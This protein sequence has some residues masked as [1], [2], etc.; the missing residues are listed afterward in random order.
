MNY[1]ELLDRFWGMDRTFSDKEVILYHY[2]LYRCNSFGW[3]DTFSLSNE[4][5]IGALMCRPTAM[6][7]A[8]SGLVEAGLISFQARFGRGENSVYSITDAPQKKVRNGNTFLTKKGTEWEHLFDEKKVR[9]G[10]TFSDSS[11]SISAN[12]ENDD[13]KKGTE[14]EHLFNEKKEEKQEKKIFP[15][16]PPIKEKKEKKKSAHTI[17]AHTP[18]CAN[19][20]FTLFSE[21]APPLKKKRNPVEPHLP[22]DIEEVVTFFEKYASDKLPEWK[23]EAELFFY[24]FDS[25]GWMGTSN[26]KIQDWESRANLWISDKALALKNGEREKQAEI[27]ARN[28]RSYGRT[29][30]LPEEGQGEKASPTGG[31]NNSRKPDDGGKDYTKGF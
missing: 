1:T 18:M 12:K 28:L 7:D 20:Q 17:S 30:G 22:K 11:T 5:L 8:R 27:D 14:L 15:P 26:R 29:T 2:L 4:E 3:P 31:R 21:E 23:A 6:R 13:E 25:V 10:N 16:A 9:N 19:G 24:H